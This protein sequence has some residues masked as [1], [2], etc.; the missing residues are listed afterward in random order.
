VT[1]RAVFPNPDHRLLPGMF[2]R[3]KLVDGVATQGLLVPQRGVV[4]N[5]RGTPTA[6]VV[7]GQGKIEVRDLV[8][9]RAIGSNWLVT[10]G[11]KDG[12]KVVVEGLQTIRPGLEVA[13]H[14]VNAQP[15][16]AAVAAPAPATP[17]K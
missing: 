3:A 6:Y 8:T 2:V 16:A 14:E 17:A 11:L 13:A 1:L 5:Q 9:D 12:D 7:D 10:S 15:P 4:R